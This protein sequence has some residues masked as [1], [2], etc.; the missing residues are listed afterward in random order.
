M[1]Q[2]RKHW[3]MHQKNDLIKTIMEEMKTL[4]QVKS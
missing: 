3:L 1:S 4:D 2:V